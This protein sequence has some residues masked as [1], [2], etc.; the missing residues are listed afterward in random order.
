MITLFKWLAGFLLTSILLIALAALI[1]PRVVDPND[2]RDNIARV[3]KQETGRDLALNG[4]LSISVFPWL[5][6]RT[7]QLSL[8]QPAEIGGKMLSVQSAQLRVRLLPLFSKQLEIDTVVLERPEL[9][10]VTLKSGTNSFSGLN[11]SAPDSSAATE[12]AST[13]VALLIQGV[14]LTDGRLVWDDRSEGQ[15]IEVANFQLNTGNLIGTE[16]AELQASGVIRDEARADDTQFQLDGAARID[17]NTLELMAQGM[18]IVLRQGQQDLTIN[19]ADFI[20]D[21]V[22]GVTALGIELGG[23]LDL[24]SDTASVTESGEAVPE[25]ADFNITLESLTHDLN[26]GVSSGE[27]VVLQVEARLADVPTVSLAG[28]MP[29]LSFN[30]RT[31]HFTARDLIANGKIGD[32]DLQLGLPSI[33]A[34]LEQQFADL[35]N[36]RINSEDLAMSFSALTVS[37]FVDNPTAAGKL[38]VQPFNL[39]TLLKQLEIDYQPADETVLQEVSAQTQFSAS[40]VALNLS[41]L[42]LQ[43]DESTLRGSFSAKDFDNPQ[44]EFDL[45]LDQ[46]DLDAYLPVDEETTGDPETTVSG[47][48]ALAVPMAL[49][50]DVNANGGFKAQRLVSGGLE[51]NDI[52]VAVVSSP[53]NLTI[54]PKAQLYDGS[55]GGQMAFSQSGEQAKLTVQ[56]EIDLVSLAKFLTAA[57]VS[58]QLSGIGSLGLD[59]VVTELDGVQKN[60]G[61]IKLLA[62][63]GA[64]KGV[65]IKAMLDRG[66]EAYQSFRGKDEGDA[67]NPTEPKIANGGEE[68]AAT[69][70]P[71]A[72]S[73]QGAESDE[74]RFAELL[75]TFHLKDNRLTNDDFSLK[76][77]LFRVS[78]SGDFD[79][80]GEQIDYLLN[81]SIVNTTSG[82][83]GEALEKL[84]G[85]T[86]PIRL[87]GSLL[88]PSYSL[89]MKALYKGLL[90]REVEEKKAEFVEE[91]F[92]IEGA[93]DLS[94]KDLLKQILIN[95]VTKK[96]KR[97]QD[98]EGPGPGTEEPVNSNEQTNSQQSSDYT[99]ASESGPVPDV[100]A[101]PNRVPE[102]NSPPSRETPVEEPYQPYGVP[103]GT[104]EAESATEPPVSDQDGLQSQEQDTRTEK[105]KLR[106]ELAEKLLES[107]FD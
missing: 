18:E 55:L 45:A 60:E 78:G 102:S 14:E 30:T 37:E 63:N 74:T 68:G 94:T 3:V 9:E 23:K 16:L 95:E 35:G 10:L 25:P 8:S 31:A 85:L 41:D 34:N 2:Y 99:D 15:R 61:T 5:G 104:A 43:L 54:T 97:D 100:Y 1:V 26:T 67:Q 79:L 103:D 69:S 19:M 105:E 32:R 106:D 17:T 24:A 64:I 65:D 91:K 62:K 56:N 98:Q 39:A 4:D 36:A 29:N 92:G 6:I 40:S 47:A 53:G 101:D 77:P 13:A 81:V 93:G 48:E 76:A 90:A 83:G 7:Q 52:D 20:L 89:D 80:A 84:K 71:N 50:K 88:A 107:I 66:Y 28:S 86:I 82:Q 75:G 58:D 46:L 44:L 33:Q 72:E 87:S 22:Q 38:T 70:E 42:A 27:N 12:D 59:L 57:D 51:L 21:Q 73:G 96:N 49:L 11:D